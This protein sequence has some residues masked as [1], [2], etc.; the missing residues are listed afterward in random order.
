MGKRQTWKRL[1][2]RQAL[3]G[4][5]ALEGQLNPLKRKL[6]EDSYYRFQ[7]IDEVRL[8][9]QLGVCID[10]NRATVDDWL[11][12]PGISIHQARTLVELSRTGV[13]LTCWED[14]AAVTGLGLPQLQAFGKMV[15]FYYYDPDSAILPRQINV[16]RVS[17]GELMA[18]PGM[19]QALAQRL[20]Y[21]RQRFGAY[22]DWLDIKHRLQLRPQ[23]IARLVHYLRF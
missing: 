2:V 20:V 22:K 15:K 3:R 4:L 7:S 21:C 5:D 11:R 12:L 14:V 19:E 17:A 13:P 6:R 16:N 18:I 23:T 8:G 1:I 9:E 10:A